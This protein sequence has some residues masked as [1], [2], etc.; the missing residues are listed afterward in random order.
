[1][2]VKLMPHAVGVNAGGEFCRSHTI[3]PFMRT[4]VARLYKKRPSTVQ[5][6]Y[7]VDAIPKPEQLAKPQAEIAAESA[8]QAEIEV[9]TAF[10]AVK[11][12][13]TQIHR[14]NKQQ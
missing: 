3:Q 2:S 5:R 8:A 12:G 4:R 14:P 13:V 10:P 11:R 1:M 9:H 6:R 7:P